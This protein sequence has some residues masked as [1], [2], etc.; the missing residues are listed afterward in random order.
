MK[1]ICENCKN[2]TLT[3]PNLKFGWCNLF[4]KQTEWNA[5]I[6]WQ[7]KTRIRICD[8]FNKK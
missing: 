5:G 4:N 2:W 3:K 1:T 6:I 7:T 8:G